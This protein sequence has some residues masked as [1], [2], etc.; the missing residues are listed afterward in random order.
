[1]FHQGALWNTMLMVAC[2]RGLWALACRHL[3][4]QAN[5][6]EW[7]SRAIGSSRASARLQ[8]IYRLLDEAD[9]SR[10]LIGASNGLS[11]MAMPGS[12]WSDCGTPERLAAALAGNSA[13]N[14][15]PGRATIVS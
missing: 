10:D 2:G 15:P 3:P 1:L 14:R 6:L 11:A 4:Q 9:F 5:L 8:S 7:Y 13:V 12:G